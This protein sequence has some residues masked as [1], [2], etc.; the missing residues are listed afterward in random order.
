[1]KKEF[2]EDYNPYHDQFQLDYLITVKSGGTTA[3]GQYMQAVR[4]LATRDGSLK[5][6]SFQKEELLIDIQEQKTIIETEIQ[7]AEDDIKVER[8]KIML[9]R[10][11][12]GLEGHAFRVKHTQREHD[13]FEEQCTHLKKIVGPLTEETKRE[14]EKVYWME[15]AKQMAAID[16][17]L[18]GGLQRATYELLLSFP[19]SIRHK[20]L[21][22]ITEADKLVKANQ[23]MDNKLLE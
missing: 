9:R 5:E 10:K 3:Y 22:D 17:G 12:M 6:L 1:M 2:Q 11:E 4:E 18:G 19:I 16:F 8:A 14:Y 21:Q 15:R 7:S 20:I 13:R 23:S